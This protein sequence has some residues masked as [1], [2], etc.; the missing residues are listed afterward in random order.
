MDHCFS[1]VSLLAVELCQF[2]SL[3]VLLKVFSD[4]LSH[5][6]HNKKCLHQ[7]KLFKEYIDYGNDIHNPTIS[8]HIQT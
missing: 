2:A 3:R 1:P 8:G 6:K 5:G 7:K 4:P